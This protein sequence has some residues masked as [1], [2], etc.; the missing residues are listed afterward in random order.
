MK[1][2]KMTVHKALCELKTLDARINKKIT[3]GTFV[4]ANKHSNTKIS[5]MSISDFSMGVKEN[6]QSIVDL[7]NRRNAI[8]RAV[9]LSNATTKVIIAG[10][11][12]TVAEAIDMKNSGIPLQQNLLARIELDMRKS[13]KFADDNNGPALEARA[14]DYIKALYG[15]SDSKGI[16]DEIKK[17]RSDFMSTQ[18]VEIVDPINASAEIERLSKQIDSF[19][20]DIDSA[21]S[22]SNALTEITIAY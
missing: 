15:S 7:M 2:E 3:S 22:V 10:V 6:Y 4:F 18:V 8:K 1:T 12:Y 20:V 14:D 11:E 21:L 17:V 13:S 9:T 5:G 19:T 16:S